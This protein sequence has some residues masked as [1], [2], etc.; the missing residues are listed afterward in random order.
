MNQ[1]KITIIGAGP[2]GAST[3]LYLAE[4]KISCTLIDKSTFPRE[5]VC[6]DAFSGFTVSVL[7]KISPDLLKEFLNTVPKTI[8]PGSRFFSPNMKELEIKTEISK[9]TN[10]EEAYLIKRIDFDNFLVSK[11]RENKNIDF[12]EG[13]KVEEVKREN[14]KISLIKSNNEIISESDLVVFANN[15]QPAFSEKL[16]NQSRKHKRYFYAQRAYFENVEFEKK[17]FIEIYFVKDLLPG[18]FWIFPSGDNGANV[19]FGSLPSVFKKRSAKE[20]SD[21]LI[22]IN[23]V[24]KKRFENAT[25]TDPWKGMKI[26]FTK[27][28]EQLSGDNFI[29]VGDAAYLANPITGEGIGQAMYSGYFAGKQ[30]EN[31]IQNNDFSASALKAYDEMINQKFGKLNKHYFLGFKVIKSLFFT[32]AIFSFLSNKQVQ[33]RWMKYIEKQNKTTF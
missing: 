22:N 20:F 4:K 30:I 21:Y 11:I 6:G 32:N 18:Y 26:P 19:G 29:N 16:L 2:A 25:Q 7:N 15:N 13:I 31:A 5:K 9:L 23:P 14:G 1:P 24:F 10:E 3:A 27:I 28:F 8:C 12:L 17:G 33:K